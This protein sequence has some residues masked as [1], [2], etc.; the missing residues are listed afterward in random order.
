MG[1]S[2]A[3]SCV[4]RC[5]C[6]ARLK[7]FHGARSDGFDRRPVIAVALVV[8]TI[9][10]VAAALAGAAVQASRIPVD[11]TIMN[12]S[13]NCRK[14]WSLKRAKSRVPATIPR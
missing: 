10:S 5:R 2:L 3:D 1:G 13:V 9:A 12:T 7:V 6:V 14:R 8:C 4:R 11:T